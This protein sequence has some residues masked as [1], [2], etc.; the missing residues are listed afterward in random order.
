MTNFPIPPETIVYRAIRKSVW[1]IEGELQYTAFVLNSE[2]NEEEL[3][4]LLEGNCRDGEYCAAKARACYGE[5]VLKAEA[6]INLG[7][8]VIPT[9]REDLPYHVSVYG[10]PAYY[11]SAEDKE[12]SEARNIADEITKSVIDVRRKRFRIK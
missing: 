4:V 6:F 12:E 3:S 1:V 2:K 7:L 8:T 10:L 5:I 9:P 11:E